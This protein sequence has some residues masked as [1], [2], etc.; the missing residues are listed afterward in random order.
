[1]CF[2]QSMSGGSNREPGTNTYVIPMPRLY[3]FFFGSLVFYSLFYFYS[4]FILYLLF[5][6]IPY[7]LVSNL[8]EHEEKRKWDY[9]LKRYQNIMVQESVLSTRIS[10]RNQCQYFAQKD[11]LNYMMPLPPF[12]VNNIKLIGNSFEDLSTEQLSWCVKILKTTSLSAYDKN[13]N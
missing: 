12:W 1:M 10:T 9:D 3:L 4:L 13:G 5:F 7:K 2:H 11:I 8:F 6:F